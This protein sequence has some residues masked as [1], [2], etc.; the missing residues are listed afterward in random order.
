MDIIGQILEMD[1]EAD[2][3][4]TK[5]REEGE[6]KLAHCGEQEQELIEKA[7]E[8]AEAYK[9]ERSEETDKAVEAQTLKIRTEERTRIKKLDAVY[10]SE[11]EKWEDDIVR[12]V[13]S[14]G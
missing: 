3:I 9:N 7:A 2:R 10:E 11:H 1:A 5:A 12:A 14:Q 8:A 6:E 4:V 13:I